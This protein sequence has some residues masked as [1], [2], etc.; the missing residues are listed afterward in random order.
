MTLIL[1][2]NLIDDIA[3]IDLYFPK[4]LKDIILS[5]DG[6]IAENE[7]N[8]RRY[9]LRFI[10]REKM[11]KIK[12]RL[13]NEHT[14]SD[15]IKVLLNL[16]KN[17]NFGLISDAGLPCIAD[18]GSK[19]VFLSHQSNIKVKALTGPSSI[20]LALMLSGLNGQKFAFQ[21]YLPRDENQLIQKIKFLESES[22]KQKQTQI[23][24]EAPYRSDK[25]FNILKKSLNKNTLL[26]IA[27]NLSSKDEKVITQKV[28]LWQ[29]QKLIIGKNPAIFLFQSDNHGS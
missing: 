4:D 8:A 16:I 29:K 11:Q 3:N 21:G 10:D 15:E 2:P 14:T 26:S 28:S 24:I 23:F 5:L 1:L 7:K 27:I 12:I 13:L 22:L 6:L 18:P 20:F 19:L 25:L 17:E 9:L